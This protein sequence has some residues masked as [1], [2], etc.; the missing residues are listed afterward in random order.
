MVLKEGN[1]V[2][3]LHGELVVEQ[4]PVTY[5]MVRAYIATLCGPRLLHRHGRRRYGR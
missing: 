2:A 4:A 1:G 3:Q 5:G